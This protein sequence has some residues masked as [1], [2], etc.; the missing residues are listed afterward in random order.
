MHSSLFATATGLS[1]LSLATIGAS[2]VLERREVCYTDDPVYNA[3][4]SYTEKGNPAKVNTACAITLG[5]PFPT[6]CVTDTTETT[7]T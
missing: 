2:R 4:W 5:I 7:T 6:E 3:V 1:L